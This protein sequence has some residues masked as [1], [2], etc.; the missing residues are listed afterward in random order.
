METKQNNETQQSAAEMPNKIIIQYEEKTWDGPLG[1]AV[2]EAGTSQGYAQPEAEPRP[3]TEEI[4]QQRPLSD[5][6]EARPQTQS[7]TVV[8]EPVAEQ[9]DNRTS[10]EIEEE[11]NEHSEDNNVND[12]RG[13]N[14]PKT[15]ESE[16]YK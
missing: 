15:H 7:P 16:F 5:P 2:R 4:G 3:E 14:E 8:Q 11:N 10:L 12:M 9:D 13:Y 1:E 6:N